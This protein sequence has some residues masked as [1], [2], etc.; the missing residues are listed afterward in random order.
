M[1]AGKEVIVLKC[2]F[3]DEISRGV[4]IGGRSDHDTQIF[5][6]SIPCDRPCSSA[7]VPL[8][9]EHPTGGLYDLGAMWV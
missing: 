3:W 8:I 9:V 1:D 2:P 5:G 4:V 6:R 7:W